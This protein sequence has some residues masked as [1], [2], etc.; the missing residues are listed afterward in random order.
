M[1]KFTDEEWQD[2]FT[3]FCHDCFVSWRKNGYSIAAA[4]DK[5]RKETLKL[6]RNPFKDNGESVNMQ[7]LHKWSERYSHETVKIL[8][9][10]E[11]NNAL[12]D[13]RICE[14]C[15]FPMFDG[16]YIAGEF[17][18]CERCAVEGGYNGNKEQFE[19][20]VSDGNDPKNPLW[21]EIYW[22]QWDN[23]IND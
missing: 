22:S 2:I 20:D 7:A 4:F 11:E 1:G 6:R 19:K 10:Y 18:C 14:Q 9:S 13:L 8:Y 16:Y 3:K 5:A 21:D 15:G 12:S 17:Y 23:P